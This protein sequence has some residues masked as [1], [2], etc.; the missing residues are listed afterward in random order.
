LGIAIVCQ[1]RTLFDHMSVADN[2]LVNRQ[3]LNGMHVIDRKRMF[4]DAAR[5]L[6]EVNLAVDPQIPVGRLYPA[7]QQMVE[8]ARALSLQ[9]RV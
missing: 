3:P 1:E 6:A 7:Q 4:S 9:S 8:I 2:L 5:L